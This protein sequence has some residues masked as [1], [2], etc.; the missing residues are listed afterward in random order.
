MWSNSFAFFVLSGLLNKTSA[1]EFLPMALL[2]CFCSIHNHGFDMIFSFSAI[3]Q[4]AP[5]PPIGF[6][7]LRAG[8]IKSVLLSVYTFGSRENNQINSSHG[9]ILLSKKTI[10]MSSS[11]KIII[12]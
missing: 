2:A 8:L 6:S 9:I 4:R 10:F 11:I 7:I 5:Y 3:V 1:S 12:T